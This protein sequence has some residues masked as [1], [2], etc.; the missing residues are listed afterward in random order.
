M[1]KYT[2]KSLILVS[3]LLVLIGL[4]SFCGAQHVTRPSFNTNNLPVVKDTSAVF[5]QA[6]NDLTV[7]FNFPFSNFKIQFNF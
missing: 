4:A 6:S 5:K 3:S 7:N 2:I 1:S